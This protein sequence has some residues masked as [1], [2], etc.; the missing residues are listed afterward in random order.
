MH[1]RPRRI[2]HDDSRRAEFLEGVEKGM[3]ILEIRLAERCIAD[4]VAPGVLPGVGDRAFYD[5]ETDRAPAPFGEVEGNGACAAVEIV[6]CV[7]RPQPGHLHDT[8]IQRLRLGSV[9]LEKGVCR[10][11]EMQ[12]AETL[13]DKTVAIH[14]VLAFTDGNGVLPG[15]DVIDDG[16]VPARH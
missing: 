1:A 9:G 6:N 11:P 5:L 3:K 16:H 4:A 15:G 2:G 8:V 14:R 12:V 7:V 13:L 10:D